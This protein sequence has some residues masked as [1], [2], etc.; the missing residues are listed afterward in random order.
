MARDFGTG[1]LPSL[2]PAFLIAPP[3]QR[4]FDDTT[5]E[6]YKIFAF[7][8]MIARRNVKRVVRRRIL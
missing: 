1:V 8:E 7:N 3:T 2:N 4:I 6:V 5:G